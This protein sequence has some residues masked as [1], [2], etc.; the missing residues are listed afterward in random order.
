MF[1]NNKLKEFS[2]K[3][4]ENLGIP[5]NIITPIISN[6]ETNNKYKNLSE[7]VNFS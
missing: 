4:M 7:S 2:R 3:L 1:L 6:K 5:P